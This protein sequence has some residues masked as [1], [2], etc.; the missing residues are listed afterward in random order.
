M[1]VNTVVPVLLGRA[2][3]SALDGAD[4]QA[5]DAAPGGV[6]AWSMCWTRKCTT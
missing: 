3:W 2:L 6:Q 4:A 1:R 5:I